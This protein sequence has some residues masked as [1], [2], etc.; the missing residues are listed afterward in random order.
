MKF[1]PVTFKILP[2]LEVGVPLIA[3]VAKVLLVPTFKEDDNDKL[4][5][6]EVTGVYGENHVNVSELK[7]A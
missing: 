2:E 7:P 1:V 5:V 6:A 4:V 3:L